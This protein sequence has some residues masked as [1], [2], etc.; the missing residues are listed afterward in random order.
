MRGRG[1]GNGGRGGRP[2]ATPTAV[3][4]RLPLTRPGGFFI[5]PPSHSNARDGPG[6]TAPR[7]WWSCYHQGGRSSRGKGLPARARRGLPGVGGLCA[8]EGS[9]SRV[10]RLTKAAFRAAEGGA[11]SIRGRRTATEEAGTGVRQ[12]QFGP[13]GRWKG[14]VREEG[15]TR[16]ASGPGGLGHARAGPVHPE[17]PR[18]GEGETGAQRPGLPRRAQ[19]A[20]SHF[21]RQQAPTAVRRRT[22]GAARHARWDRS[23]ACLTAGGAHGDACGRGHRPSVA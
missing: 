18:E 14:C 11:R 3:A 19:G 6:L 15:E 12:A 13:W 10:G 20:F 22:G 5:S 23:I 4:R 16:Q 7:G 9:R 8:R 1:G 2:R 21:G 17:G